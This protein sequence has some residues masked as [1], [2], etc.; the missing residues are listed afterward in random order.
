MFLEACISNNFNIQTLNPK[1]CYSFILQH[2]INRIVIPFKNPQLYLIGVYEI[3]QKNENIVV[4]EENLSEV[5]K[6]GLWHLTGVRFPVKYEF[7]TYT[8]LIDKFASG[9]TPYDIMGIVLRNRKTGERTKFRNP[10]Y[11]EV[12]HLRGNQAKLQ[13]QYLC[14]RHS[15]KLPEFLKYYPETKEEMSKFRNQ[16]HM[17]T[18]N[19]HKNYISCYVK[20]VQALRLYSPQF[21]THMFKLHE[22][23]IDELK[24]KGLYITNTEVIKYVNK[25]HPSLLMYCLNFNMRKRMIDT[26]K[27]DNV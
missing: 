5:I 16:I 24:P 6:G 3:I 8:E 15:G 27:I 17:F 14:L 19:L 20:K 26:I 2:P 13:Y 12:R 21:R 7:S 18:E 1:F 23:F 9:N 11:E 25:L 10:I 4:I 22:H